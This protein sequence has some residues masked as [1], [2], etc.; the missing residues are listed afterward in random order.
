[1]GPHQREG[2]EASDTDVVGADAIEAFRSHHEMSR[3]YSRHE[4]QPGDARRY[5]PVTSSAVIEIEDVA[6]VSSPA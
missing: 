5:S 6:H 4:P 2:F 1:M 3:S